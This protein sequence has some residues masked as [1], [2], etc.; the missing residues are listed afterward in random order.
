MVQ[1]CSGVEV[2]GVG[3]CT[4]RSSSACDDRSPIDRDHDDEKEE[5]TH[6]L[7]SSSFL[8]LPYRILNMNHPKE[9]LWSLWVSLKSLAGGELL[10]P[11]N[12]C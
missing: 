7:H 10:N 9:P 8:G 6:G 12:A 4:T 2:P 5:V 11:S 1:G 3:F